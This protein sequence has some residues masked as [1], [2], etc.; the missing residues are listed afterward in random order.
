M[1]DRTQMQTVLIFLVICVQL[2]C[3]SSEATKSCSVMTQ[4]PHPQGICG[5]KISRVLHLL[6]GENGYNEKKYIKRAAIQ[7]SLT[8]FSPFYQNF[9]GKEEANSFLAKRVNFYQTG[10]SCECCYNKCSVPELVTYCNGG[11]A[12]GLEAIQHM[13]NKDLRGYPL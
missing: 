11:K 5:N 2:Y 8:D 13:V 3:V 1:V 12:K 10:I 6:C 9:Y 7:G 4:R